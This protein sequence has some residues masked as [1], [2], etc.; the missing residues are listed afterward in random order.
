MGRIVLFALCLAIWP[1]GSADQRG[2]RTRRLVEQF[3]QAVVLY[4]QRQFERARTQL[5]QMTVDDQRAAVEAFLHR[6]R[7]NAAARKVSARDPAESIRMARAAGALEMEAAAE[8][9]RKWFA[10]GGEGTIRLHIAIATDL[11]AYVAE[12]TGRSERAA[13]RWLTAIGRESL[14]RGQFQLAPEIVGPAC[15]KNPDYPPLLLTCAI[16]HES[17]SVLAYDTAGA[18]GRSATER[19]SRGRARRERSA[20]LTSARHFF[21]RSLAFGPGDGEAALRL[22]NVRLLLGQRDS[23]IA[24][25]ASVAAR[26]DVSARVTYL[27]NMFLGRA[28]ESHG[29]LDDARQAYSDALSVGQT[30]SVLLALSH[31]AQLQGR[32]TDA[33]TF[34][35]RAA[36]KTL[37]LDPWWAYTFG[38]YWLHPDLFAALRQEAIR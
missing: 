19:V 5:V 16:A 20:H 34:A 26:K 29:R 10:I 1:S 13:E 32:A 11:F 33:A 35:E 38:Q 8:E 17:A 24:M 2:E 15:G 27:A 25:L 22:G 28:Y 7:A 18:I 4:Q 37:A 31:N 12:R 14:S 6:E 23:G 9:V 36:T 3:E 21:E 30:Q